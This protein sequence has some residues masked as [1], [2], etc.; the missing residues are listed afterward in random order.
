MDIKAVCSNLPNN[1]LVSFAQNENLDIDPEEIEEENLLEF[2]EKLSYESKNDM[3]D[4]EI[5]SSYHKE[6]VH[7][8]ESA[9]TLRN[10]HDHK[11]N[12]ID[13][14]EHLDNGKNLMDEIDYASKKSDEDEVKKKEDRPEGLFELIKSEPLRPVKSPRNPFPITG[15]PVGPAI[16]DDGDSKD[17]PDKSIIKNPFPITGGPHR[18]FE[19]ING[20]ED[21]NENPFPITGG[22]VG[23]NVR[24]DDNEDIP[25]KTIVN[26]RGPITGGPVGPAIIDDGDSKDFPDK[27]II[28]NPFPITGGPHRPFEPINNEEDNNENP[29]PITGG[30]A[31][32]ITFEKQIAR[33]EDDA[34]RIQDY[35]A[36]N[37]ELSKADLERLDFDGDGEVT[38][39]DAT[40]AKTN[41]LNMKRVNILFNNPEEAVQKIQDYLAGNTELTDEELELYDFD[42]DGEVTIMDATHIQN[43]QYKKTK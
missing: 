4:A 27:S 34:Q 28:K 25:D 18:P 36:G 16:I 38:I 5:I 20:E 9:Y 35:L 26:P 3:K 21:N 14:I 42:G 7:D 43:H 37:I 30:P 40:R 22:P 8:E 39:M 31:K 6:N 2:K 1:E 12:L 41:A 11:R 33:Y 32:P 15:G 17:F 19:P 10:I 13:E 23:P 24:D 29:F